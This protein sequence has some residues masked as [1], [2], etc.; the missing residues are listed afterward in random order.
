LNDS[1]T[2]ERAALLGVYAPPEPLFVRGDGAWLEDATGRRYLDF[3]AG[4]AVSALGHDSPVVRG[5]V[6]EALATGLI[7]TSN[8]FRTA[9]AEQ[10]A[11][12]LVAATFDSR[13]F[14]CNSGGEANEAA[15]KFARRRARARGG[16]AKHE[17]VSFHGAF[18]GRLFGTLA[19][20]DRP[21]YREPFE[22]L[23]PGVHFAMVGDLDSVRAV[24]SAERTAAIIIEPLQGE[25]G[26]RVVPP[27]FLRALRAL[28]DELDAVLIL[29]EIQCGLA[30][31]GDLF[32][33]Q[34]AG[35]E[36]DML[37]LAKPLAGGLP[38]GAVLVA[39]GVAEHMRPGDHGT[40]FG[41]GPLV[42][43]VARAV[44]STLSEPAFLVG[45][46]ERAERLGEGLEAL[47]AKHDRVIEVR[48]RGLMRGL[49][50][51]GPVAP[52]LNTARESGLLLCSAGPEVIRILPPLNIEPELIDRG[53]AL[54]ESAVGT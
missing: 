26:V 29:D 42:A 46:R 32:A 33:Y 9:P 40:T 44:L 14:F 39:P 18:H 13:A 53:V 3:T 1:S 5:A 24:A 50:L 12:E 51:D 30:R 4:I 43:T 16:A 48:G 41:G 6:Q 37:T 22:P 20:T 38:M 25:G 27:D 45:V 10:L 17:I 28:C 54:L 8:L 34:R 52:V 35:I 11:R 23:M 2:L 19:A 31:T 47:V 7:H 49:V 36:P 21:S 15:F